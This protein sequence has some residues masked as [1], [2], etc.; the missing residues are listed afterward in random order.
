[1]RSYIRTTEKFKETR[2]VEK[3]YVS[4]RF[5]TTF[6]KILSIPYF[7]VR[8][9]FLAFENSYTFFPAYT[10]T[11]SYYSPPG[12]PPSSFHHHQSSPSFPASPTPLPAFVPDTSS[13]S[14]P[15]PSTSRLPQTTLVEVCTYLSSCF[16]VIHRARL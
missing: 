3:P 16:D 4:A 7:D 13:P 12:P 9:I 11:Y 14:P 6:S 10:E 8:E 1:M 2:I 15:A 5:F